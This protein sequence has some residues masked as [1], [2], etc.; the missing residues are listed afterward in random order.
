MNPIEVWT[1]GLH[2]S[3]FTSTDTV[4]AAEGLWRQVEA[5]SEMG[6]RGVLQTVMAGG[7][8][9]DRPLP[10]TSVGLSEAKSNN[11][12]WWASQHFVPLKRLRNPFILNKFAELVPHNWSVLLHILYY[13]HLRSQIEWCRT[14]LVLLGAFASE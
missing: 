2:A 7:R 10:C 14:L 11:G 9:L 5:W 6:R 1:Q 3:S 4:F 8:P 12:H 13:V